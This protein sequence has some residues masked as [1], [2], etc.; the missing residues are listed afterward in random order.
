MS[1]VRKCIDVENWLSKSSTDWLIIPDD[2]YRKLI[3]NWKKSF[4]HEIEARCQNQHGIKAQLK[5]QNVL[6]INAYIFSGIRVEAVA[7]LGGNYP[8]GYFVKELS[9]VDWSLC[10]MQELIITDAEFIHTM[11]CSHE[12]GYEQYFEIV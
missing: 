3:S 4:W 1:L 9:E 7:N 5:L 12:D 10:Q 2:E 6:P 8:L 11:V